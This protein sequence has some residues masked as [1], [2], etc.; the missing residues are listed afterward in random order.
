MNVEPSTCRT[1]EQLHAILHETADWVIHGRAGFALGHAASLREVLDNFNKYGQSGA[2]I[3]AV[4]L[5]PND[6]I[7]VFP[8]QIDRVRQMMAVT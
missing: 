7:F 8:S 1:D 6:N 5:L 4:C 2:T 3:T